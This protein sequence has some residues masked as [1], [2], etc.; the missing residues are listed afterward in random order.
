MVNVCANPKCSKPLHYLREGRI[1]VFDVPS[2]E[3]VDGARARRME[4][5]WLC[6]DCCNTLTLTRSPD[7][8]VALV[9]RPPIGLRPVVPARK[10]LVAE[11]LAS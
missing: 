11:R 6:G 9:A 2:P 4:H 8:G 1:Y 10:A 7:S 5:Y 3:R